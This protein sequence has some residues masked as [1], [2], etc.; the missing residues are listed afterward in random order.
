METDVE[1]IETDDIAYHRA[2][3]RDGTLAPSPSQ[4]MMAY[5]PAQLLAIAVEKNL[6]LDKIERLMD[7]LERH[8]KKQARS[9]FFA[10]LARFQ[11]LVPDIR[12]LKA[13][14]GG[15][16]YA[17]LG[18]IERIIRDAMQ[19]CGL[20]KRWK[21]IEGNNEVTMICVVTHVDGH[22]EETPFGPVTWDLL[23]RTN[24]MNG[25]QHRAAV[26]T[27]LQRYTLI[28]ALGLTTADED[29]DGRLGPEPTTER[30][31]ESVADKLKRPRAT[32]ITKAQAQ[33]LAAVA[34]EREMPTETAKEII[35]K[36]GFE[37][38][39][40]ITPDKFDD[41]LKALAAWT[42]PP[43]PD[44]AE[45]GHA[46][47]QSRLNIL[48]QECCQEAEGLSEET[49]AEICSKFG[50]SEIK[51]IQSVTEAENAKKLLHSAPRER[52]T[53]KKR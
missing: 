22:S 37:R 5:Q 28:G 17:P 24:R 32:V 2:D 40:D 52:K 18:D 44:T 49:I 4:A 8:E 23:E 29:I 16:F 42:A 9:A 6:D 3:Y 45:T 36:F 13:G 27:Y 14:Y 50:V 19:T 41:V 53:A 43:K 48:I 47:T 30:A 46:P 10:A 15:V 26:I 39:Q 7:L 31:T 21:Q 11:S 25:L 1:Q 34:Q 51:H 35:K 12:K 38:G 20:S 33:Q